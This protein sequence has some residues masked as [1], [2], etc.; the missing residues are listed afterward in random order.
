VYT[1]ISAE[2]N[3]TTVK[4][5]MQLRSSCLQHWGEAPTNVYTHPHT[6]Q[7]QMVCNQ[8]D[9]DVARQP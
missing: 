5:A 2:G 4:C 3:E 1:H 7:W 6:L 8:M 9:V